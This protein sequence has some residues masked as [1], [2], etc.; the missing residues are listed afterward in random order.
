MNK[1]AFVELA[2]K[3]NLGE[4]ARIMSEKILVDGR[5]PSEVAKEHGVTR[6][7][8]K[9][10]ADRILKQQSMVCELPENW[11][12]KTVLL[13]TE[14]ANLVAYISR[15]IQQ[16]EGLIICSKAKKPD[17]TPEMVQILANVMAGK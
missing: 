8:T 15:K 17:I 4:Q 6:Q 10:V 9:A 1:T 13:P 11:K 12:P 3:T 7:R 5:T 14:W 2:D 16:K